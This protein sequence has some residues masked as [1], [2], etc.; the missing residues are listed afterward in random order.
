ME[1][2]KQIN[3]AKQLAHDFQESMAAGSSVK[4]DEAA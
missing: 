1:A 2:D 3:K 4:T